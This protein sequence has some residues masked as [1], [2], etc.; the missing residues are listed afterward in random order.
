VVI[1]KKDIKNVGSLSDEDMVYLTDAFS[2]MRWIVNKE[3]LTD[4]QIHTNGR[5]LQEVTYLHF[6]LVAE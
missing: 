4:Y 1:P 2:A 3:G 6:H 5:G